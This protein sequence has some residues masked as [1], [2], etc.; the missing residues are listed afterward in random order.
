M[1]AKDKDRKDVAI[2]GW[3]RWHGQEAAVVLT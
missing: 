2:A 3:K 1:Q